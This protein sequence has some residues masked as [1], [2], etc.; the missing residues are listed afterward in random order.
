LGGK[1]LSVHVNFDDEGEVQS[2][3]FKKDGKE[4]DIIDQ[5]TKQTSI[6]IG[7]TNDVRKCKLVLDSPAR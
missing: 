2:L 6:E 3:T 7:S 4:M 1:S 5:E